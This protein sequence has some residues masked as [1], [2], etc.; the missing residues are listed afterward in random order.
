MKGMIMKT[1]IRSTLLVLAAA[2]TLPGL[3]A[4]QQTGIVFLDSERLRQEAPSLQT[5]RQQLQ[6]EMAQLEAQADSALAPLQAEFQAAAQEYQ[7]QQGMMTADRQQEQERA[8]GQMQ[9]RL[10]QEGAQWEQQ[11]AQ[12]QNRILGPA[13]ERINRVI[14]DIRSENGYQ[15]VLDVAA[16]GVVAADPSLDITSEVLRRLQASNPGS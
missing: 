10:Q 15:F 2:V 9:Q 14:D 7:Q 3:A 12:L 16:G 11:A 6:E 8:L 1:L 4:A 13:L 5:A